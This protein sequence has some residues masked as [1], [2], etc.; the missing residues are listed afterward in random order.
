MSATQLILEL[1]H[2]PAYK[3][4][5][6]FVADCNAEAVSMIDADLSWAQPVKALVGPKASG[7]SH[8][9]AVWGLQVNADIFSVSALNEEHLLDLMDAPA[10][11]IDD[12]DDIQKE[13]EE[14][15]FHLFNNAV[16]TR[17]ALLLCA[18]QPLSKLNIGLP[19]LVSRLCAVETARLEAPCENLMSAVM[20]KLF[21]DRQIRVNEKII[22]YILPR[23]ERS[24][25]GINEIV[26]R[27]DR[28]SLIGKKAVTIPLI[29]HVLA[30]I[31][32]R[33]QE[34]NS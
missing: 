30:E 5:D 15:V 4:E 11:V 25:A 20:V 28:A 27:V 29:S 12:L 21:Y 9:A 8:L 22:S 31:E 26:D 23:M 7:K 6:F 1:P 19:D 32:N 33:T 3:R 10:L 24:F 13:H 16:Q 14:I 2:L 17:K 18:C 34:T